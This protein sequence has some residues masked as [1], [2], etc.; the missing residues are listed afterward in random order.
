LQASYEKRADGCWWV[1]G[2]PCG[3]MGPYTTKEEAREDARGVRDFYRYE[4]DE[5]QPEL[6][7]GRKWKQGQKSLFEDM[8]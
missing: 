3:D 5:V 7:E 8:N 6:I 1:V 2:F 4:W